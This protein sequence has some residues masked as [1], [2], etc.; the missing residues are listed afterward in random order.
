MIGAHVDRAGRAAIT[1]ALVSPFDDAAKRDDDRDT[2]NRKPKGGRAQ[3]SCQIGAS[4]D[5]YE[6]LDGVCS[7]QILAQQAET[8]PARHTTLSNVLTDDRS[9]PAYSQGVCSQYLTVELRVTNLLP[10]TDCGCR[11]T[12]YDTIDASYT[13]RTNDLSVGV[14]DGVPV[15][16][17]VS[18]TTIF[19]FL[20]PQ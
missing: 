5:V 18:S 7:N 6:G 3:F 12:L 17:V 15:D 20:K 10:N 9:Y 1:T 4:L 11:M 16:N 8:G 2:Y 14:T 13:A 19:P